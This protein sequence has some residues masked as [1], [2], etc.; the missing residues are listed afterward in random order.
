MTETTDPFGPE[1]WK[2]HSASCTCPDCFA[3]ASEQYRDPEEGG[4]QHFRDPS[5]CDSCETEAQN[6]ASIDHLV[7]QLPELIASAQ[8]AVS[9]VRGTLD[10][11]MSNHVYD[12]ELAESVKGV[13]AKDDLE[14]ASRLLRNV[15]LLADWRL[16]IQNGA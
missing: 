14:A 15:A 7:R 6:A 3:H 12:V 10:E 5:A 2:T 16:R 13:D 4:C 11:L 8:R 9:E 1:A